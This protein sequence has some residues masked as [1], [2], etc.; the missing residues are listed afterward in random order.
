MNVSARTAPSLQVWFLQG[1]QMI[2]VD[3]PGSTVED[4]LRQL[5]AGPTSTEVA[6]GI[7]TYVPARTALRSVSVGDGLA[8]IDVGARFVQGNDAPS[9]L[10]RLSQLVHTAAGP[11][12]AERVQLLVKG[13]RP[14]GV[15]PGV[16]TDVPLTVDFL[17]TPSAEA[18]GPPLQIDAPAPPSSGARDAQQRPAAPAYPLP[19]ALH[20]R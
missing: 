8:T 5:L 18:E 17:Q 20:G 10:A 2:A 16:G 19:G 11:E 7:R 14:P 9:L 4:A 6:R 12:G 1:E 15:F 3:R 13:E